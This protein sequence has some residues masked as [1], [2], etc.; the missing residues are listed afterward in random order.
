MVSVAN[1]KQRSHI[2]RSRRPSEKIEA[3]NQRRVRNAGSTRNATNWVASLIIGPVLNRRDA[4]ILKFGWACSRGVEVRRDHGILYALIMRV[5][6]LDMGGYPGGLRRLSD[7]K[8]RVASVSTA[9]VAKVFTPELV[10]GIMCVAAEH[11]AP[12]SVECGGA[13]NSDPEDDSA[14]PIACVV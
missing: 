11:D 14:R 12:P 1:N 4:N 7:P 13:G 8:C 3:H 2:G 5:P 6:M 9:M 10:R